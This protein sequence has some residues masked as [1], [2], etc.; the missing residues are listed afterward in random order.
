MRD[1]TV[2]VHTLTSILFWQLDVC[3][4]NVTTTFCLQQMVG[5]GSKRLAGDFCARDQ[6]TSRSK[7]SVL[8]QRTIQ[9]LQFQRRH[10]ITWCEW[11]F[12]VLPK[13]AGSKV[14]CC[15]VRVIRGRRFVC[16]WRTPATCRDAHH[17]ARRASRVTSRSLELQVPRRRSHFRRQ[18]N[19][20]FHKVGTVNDVVHVV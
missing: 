14:Y 1:H 5:R 9:C 10:I 6:L 19:V 18:R 11:L 7:S 4:K 12:L 17:C 20:L 2:D 3:D 13:A 16:N 15:S 8:V